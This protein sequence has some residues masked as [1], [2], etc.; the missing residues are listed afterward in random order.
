M[1]VS[2]TVLTVIS[3]LLHLSSAYADCVVFEQSECVQK[4]FLS[5]YFGS[6]EA[7]AVSF[8]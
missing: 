1:N 6:K 7:F 4:D 5:N 8:L 3:V 2:A